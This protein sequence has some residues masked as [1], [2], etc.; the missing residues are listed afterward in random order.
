MRIPHKTQC[1]TRVSQN[2]GHTAF[3][4]MHNLMNTRG[5]HKQCIQGYN[6]THQSVYARVTEL[7]AYKRNTTNMTQGKQIVTELTAY[8]RN[9]K[10]MTQGIQGSQN[11]LHINETQKT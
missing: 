2:T 7:T 11:L 1:T 3:H 6:K 9:T 5:H 10:H 4:I 8:K